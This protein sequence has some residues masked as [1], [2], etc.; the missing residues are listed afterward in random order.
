MARAEAMFMRVWEKET[1]ALAVLEQAIV[2]YLQVSLDTS[3]HVDIVWLIV[4]EHIRILGLV[5]FF[6]FYYFMQFI[7][8]SVCI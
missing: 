1:T 7:I 2:M 8:M 6:P 4:G 5:F 3:K